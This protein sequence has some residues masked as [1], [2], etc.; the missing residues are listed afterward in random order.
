MTTDILLSVCA[1]AV[2]AF[3]SFWGGFAIGIWIARREA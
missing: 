1:G 3:V 2:V